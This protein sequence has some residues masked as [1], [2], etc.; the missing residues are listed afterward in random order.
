MTAR[1]IKALERRGF[2]P[3]ATGYCYVSGNAAIVDSPKYP[4]LYRVV[5][6]NSDGSFNRQGDVC[7]IQ[8]VETVTSMWE[9][10][11]ASN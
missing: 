9:H 5:L 8:E 10:S 3:S 2:R 1:Q 7:T 11:L 6:L 4:G